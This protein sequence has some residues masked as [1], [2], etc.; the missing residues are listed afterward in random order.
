MSR[1]N[2]IFALA[3]SAKENNPNAK[4]LSYSFDTIK[5]GFT[6][7]NPIIEKLKESNPKQY[8]Q[9]ETIFNNWLKIF[10]FELPVFKPMKEYFLGKGIPLQ[11]ISTNN[12]YSKLSLFSDIDF[13]NLL[14]G[15]SNDFFTQINA[16]TLFESGFINSIEKHNVDLIIQKREQK[17][18]LGY[19]KI[20]T[21][22][23]N[24]VDEWLTD[25]QE[26][27]DKLT[28]YFVQPNARLKPELKI[29][30]IALKYAYE[31]FQITRKNGDGIAKK[32]GHNSGEKLFQR[33]TYYSSPANRKGKPS[34]CTPKT[35]GNKIKLIESVMELLPTD[36][37]Q[38]AKDEV[39]ILKK[40]YEA[41][42]E[43]TL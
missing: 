30:Q 29:D 20:E 14:I 21:E 1:I 39:S 9:T 3:K 26:A 4:G 7:Y 34:P 32:H 38:R 6:F 33:F 25:E 31:S 15:I 8:E 36:K 42:Y 5:H 41:E 22:F 27:W 10:P 12:G 35:L 18:K 17:T 16:K 40:I 28:P 11:H 43:Q 37:Q 19:P 13:V 2:I 23:S 24:I